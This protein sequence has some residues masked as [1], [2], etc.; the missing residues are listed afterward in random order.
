MFGKIVITPRSNTHQIHW[1]GCYDFLLEMLLFF[2]T[3][4]SNIISVYKGNQVINRNISR[5]FFFGGFCHDSNNFQGLG[6][7]IFRYHNM[8]IWTLHDTTQGLLN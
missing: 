4:V 5:L 8:Q 1:F 7:A 2:W 6:A 3:Q